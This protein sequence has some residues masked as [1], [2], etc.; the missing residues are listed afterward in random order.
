MSSDTPNDEPDLG[1]IPSWYREIF[2]AGNNKGFFHNLGNHSALFVD[3][4]QHQLVVSFDNLSDAGNPRYDRDAWAGKFCADNGWSHLGVLSQVPHWYRDQAIIDFMKKLSSDG[5]F[6]QFDRVAFCGTSMGGFAALTFSSLA[7]GATV[8]AFSP[9][10]TLRSDL[11]PWDKRFAKGRRADWALEYSDAAEQISSAHKVYVVF[12]PFFDLDKKH[13]NRL[14][15]ENIMSLHGFGLGHKSALVLRR[16]DRLK[17]IMFDAITGVLTEKRFYEL[18]R[19]RKDVYLYRQ[20]IETYLIQRDRENWLPLF[21]KAFKTRRRK[22]KLA[23][24]AKD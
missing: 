17:P 5:F 12:D 6:E 24:L 21:R 1:G 19:A 4:G 18:M 15:G 11:V 8:I 3:R 13:Y 23:L 16:M 7:P 10:T 20:N 22:A 2:P 14:V 9:Q